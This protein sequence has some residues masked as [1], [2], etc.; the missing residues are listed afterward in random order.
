MSNRYIWGAAALA[1]ILLLFG[2]VHAQ[3]QSCTEVDASHLTCHFIPK[4][5]GTHILKGTAYA[6]DGH[7]SPTVWFDMKVNDVAC[8]QRTK[9][10]FNGGDGEVKGQCAVELTKGRTYKLT[11]IGGNSHANAAGV[12]LRVITP[13]NMEITFP[14]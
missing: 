2:P 12:E 8:G 4:E 14:G 9:T 5:S 10:G 11:I 13:T 7:S 1:A 3:S 6:K